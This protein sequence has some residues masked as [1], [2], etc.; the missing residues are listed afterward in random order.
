MAS[1]FNV[2]IENLAEIKR[3]F[4]KAPELTVKYVDRA[5]QASLFAVQKQADP[6][7]PVLTGN[8]RANNSFIYGKLQ[9]SFIKN[10]NYAIYVH[11]GT[12]FMKGR[13][14]LL[15][16]MKSAEPAIQKYFVDAVQNVLD[17]IG[18]MV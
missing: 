1:T 16:G 13:P 15:E 10:A 12:R 2:K 3:A 5:I 11:E 8:L 7:T 17:D 9:G 4:G 14:F 6:L 18:H